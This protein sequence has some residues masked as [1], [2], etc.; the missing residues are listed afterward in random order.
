MYKFAPRWGFESTI[1]GSMFRGETDG[2]SEL[3][4]TGLRT[5]N[6]NLRSRSKDF[7]P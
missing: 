2:A 5:P 7:E 3:E 6:G 4:I 1:M